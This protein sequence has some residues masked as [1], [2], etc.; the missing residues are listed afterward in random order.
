MKK[1]WCRMLVF[2]AL[3]AFML[4]CLMRILCVKSENGA[5]Q[6]RN[7]YNQP[8][9]TI[10]VLFLGSSHVHCNVDTRVLWEQE[11]IAA[12]LLTTA[13]QPVW[14]SYHY[15]LEAL[16]TQT[17]KLVVV[18]MF[19]PVRFMDDI[20]EAWL[21]DNLDGMRFSGNKWKAIQA[22]APSD[23]M[24]WMLGFPRYHD[25][26]DDLVKEDFM[27]FW[28]NKKLLSTWKGFLELQNHAALTE[29][30]ISQVTE[31]LP[32]T[33]KS[34]MYFEKIM[35]VCEQ[36]GIQ[37]LF[38]TAPYLVEETD[39]MRFNEISRQAAE[40][41]LLFKDYN[42]PEVYREM[43]MDFSLDFADHAHLNAQGAVKYTMHLAS[44]LKQNYE[45][46]DRRGQ[47]GYESW[48]DHGVAV[49]DHAD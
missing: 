30:D 41:G 48:E 11:G 34:Q 14:N 31:S 8:G 46:P 38:L 40:H 24:E 25:R 10:D 20:Q 13:E 49:R 43:G 39:Q 28:W 9:N 44:W 18:D 2:L 26:Y 35:E 36:K 47:K 21:G 29:P 37:L 32:L 5:S 6:A 16:K 4:A 15:L 7:L 27:N 17:P 33:E 1:R 12:Y 3:T 22:S 23:H 42:Q 45:I 19:G